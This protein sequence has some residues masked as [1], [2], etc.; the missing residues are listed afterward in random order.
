MPSTR[1]SR[2]LARVPDHSQSCFDFFGLPAEVRSQIIGCIEAT[3]RDPDVAVDLEQHEERRRCNP[4]ALS[5]VLVLSKQCYSEF[6]PLFYSQRRVRFNMDVLRFADDYLARC[7]P[8]CLHNLRYLECSLYQR[9]V[10]KEK[11]SLINFHKHL[12][13]REIRKLATLFECYNELQLHEFVLR[14]YATGYAPV[15][16]HTG[17]LSMLV[18]EDRCTKIDRDNDSCFSRLTSPRNGSALY[19]MSSSWSWTPQIKR[20]NHTDGRMTVRF[21]RST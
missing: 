18:Y 4:S 13:A 1:R 20:A 14:Y 8:Q 7:T 9:N 12:L 21:L 5:N 15:I 6:A 16:L 3:S 2:R 19:G 10:Y 17:M 11:N